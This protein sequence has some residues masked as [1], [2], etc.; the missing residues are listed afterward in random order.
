LLHHDV[1]DGLVGLHHAGGADQ[2]HVA[3]GLLRRLAADAVRGLE[4]HIAHG[5]LGTHDGGVGGSSQ[6]QGTADLAAVADHTGE[7]AAHVDDGLADLLIAAAH[8]PHHG[9]GGGGGGRDA[10]A[11]GGRQ[12]AGE[13]LDI[14][15]QGVGKG[16]RLFQL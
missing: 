12:L 13:D 8:Q 2:A 16:Q 7:V 14:H 15:V 3:D 11:A 1:Q 6:L 5:Q 4:H 10:A 9:R